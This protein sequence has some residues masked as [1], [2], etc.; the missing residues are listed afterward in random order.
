MDR[1]RDELMSKSVKMIG[2][3]KLASVGKGTGYIPD[4][5]NHAQDLRLAH[6]LG[7]AVKAAPPE[8]PT[9]DPRFFPKIRDQDELGSCV[10]HGVRS[11]LMYHL[12]KRDQNL[13]S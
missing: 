6:R 11:G 7:D 5:P 9:L 2:R 10:G 12:V 3:T 4:V 8:N 13:W 1:L